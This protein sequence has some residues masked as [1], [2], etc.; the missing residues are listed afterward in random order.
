VICGFYVVCVAARLARFN[1]TTGV[2]SDRFF[3]GIP[4]TYTGGTVVATFLLLLKYGDPAW[5][6]S[7]PGDDHL[8]L[9][10]ARRLDAWMPWLPLL[11]VPGGLGM[12]STLRMPKVGPTG[13]R[14]LDVIEV[15]AIV[16]GFSAG[17]AHR[18]P[19]YLACGA[20]FYLGYTVRYHLTNERARAMRLPPLFTSRPSP[21]REPDRAHP[22]ASGGR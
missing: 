5:T 22:P 7:D 1:I 19:E 6:A 4:T 2:H 13:Y 12:I 3:F 20:L 8:Y 9:F 15:I 10:G 17:L 18:F 16:A 21:P 14:T 11:L